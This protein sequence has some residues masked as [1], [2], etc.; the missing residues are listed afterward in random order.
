MHEMYAVALAGRFA[1]PYLPTCGLARVGSS[2]G[3][4]ESKIQMN[5]SLRRK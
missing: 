4:K 1:L 2:V 5:E 3:R